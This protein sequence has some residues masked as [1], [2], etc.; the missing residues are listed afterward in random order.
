MY[1]QYHFVVGENVGSYILYRRVFVFIGSAHHE[2]S[3]LVPGLLD[4][5]V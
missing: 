5:T 3:R 1:E 4:V 2:I